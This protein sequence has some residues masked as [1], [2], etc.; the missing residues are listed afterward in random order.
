[1]PNPRNKTHSHRSLCVHEKSA[2]VPACTHQDSVLFSF[3]PDS[4]RMLQLWTRHGHLTSCLLAAVTSLW[5][6]ASRPW[7]VTERLYRF[8]SRSTWIKWAPKIYTT[9]QSCCNYTLS[10][11]KLTYITYNTPASINLSM[12]GVYRRASVQINLYAR[13]LNSSG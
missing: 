3:G 1:M 7:L 5:W 10:Q 12:L 4:A 8:G 9:T 2:V 13:F 6:R 11:P